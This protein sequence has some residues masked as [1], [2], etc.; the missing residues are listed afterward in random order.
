MA[1]SIVE[2]LRPLFLRFLMAVEPLAP[3]F[4]SLYLGRELQKLRLERLIDGYSAKTKRL[5]RYHYRIMIEVDVERH[6]ASRLFDVIVADIVR[7]FRRWFF[8]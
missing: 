8:G 1:I 7:I 3:S 4:I 6:Q 2:R 5:G